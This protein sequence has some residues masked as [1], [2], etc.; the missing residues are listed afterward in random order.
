MHLPIYVHLPTYNIEKNYADWYVHA[1][2]YMICLYVN[3]YT[4]EYYC[5]YNYVLGICIMYVKCNF[6][7][8]N[9]VQA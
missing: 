3:M 6:F 4:R 5:P 8:V 2:I 1:C 9:I 7:W